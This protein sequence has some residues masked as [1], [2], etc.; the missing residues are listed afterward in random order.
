M[1]FA[2][3]LRLYLFFNPGFWLEPQKCGQIFTA[4]SDILRKEEQIFDK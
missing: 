2:V 3:L 4:F 1:N